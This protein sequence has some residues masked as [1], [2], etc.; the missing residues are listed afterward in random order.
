MNSFNVS[1]VTTLPKE[2]NAPRVT[3]TGTDPQTYR[4][5]FH[6][7]TNGRATLISSGEC[8]TN[9]T[10]IAKA[11]QWYTLWCITVYDEQ[12]NVVFIDDF[13][14]TNKVAFI[15]IDAFALGDTIAWIPYV[16]AF[17]V[18]HNCVVICS[19][20]HNEILI[21]AYP[22]IMFVKPN[23][24]IEN[25]YAQYYVG[26]INE[27]NPYYS[28]IKANKS[29]LQII[30]AAILGLPYN[31]ICPN[32]KTQIEFIKP[33]IE[34]NYVCISEF[35]SHK[36]K[37]WKVEDGWQTI[38]DFL[39]SIGYKVVVISKEPTTLTDVI[40][41]TG[42]IS[43]FDRM[44]DLMHAD[45]FI[46]ISSG[47]SWLSWSVGTHTVMISD[48]TPNFHEFQSNIT[49]INCNDLDAVNYMAEGQSSIENVLEKL[50][51]LVLS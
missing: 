42:D 28:P 38:V 27:E 14:L 7:V 17:R 30:A 25:V 34:G 26:A 51:E 48:V 39:N 5:I 11:K 43:L 18:K 35:G 21:K 22:N 45:F 12:N 40:N 32:L 37:E 6:D 49:R 2:G 24:I 41:K 10:I 15:K 9:Q 31:E 47:L 20:F 29:P 44:V 19:T 23:T 13:D 36:D 50:G 16:E 33:N 1:Y 46:G 4:V 8:K 3:I